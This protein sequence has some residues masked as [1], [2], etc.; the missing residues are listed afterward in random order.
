MGL[1]ESSCATLRVCTMLLKAVLLGNPLAAV[2]TR[3]HGEG[4]G[5]AMASME[6]QARRRG[7]VT[8][9]DVACMLMREQLDEPSLLERMCGRALGLAEEEIRRDAALVEFVV[10]QQ[11]Q[12]SQKQTCLPSSAAMEQPASYIPP[13]EFY[14]SF[15]ALLSSYFNGT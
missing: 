10:A 5:E 6:V 4:G 14:V 3:V 15:A 12:T 8:P 1:G 13:P 7:G 11:K 2:Q 9:K